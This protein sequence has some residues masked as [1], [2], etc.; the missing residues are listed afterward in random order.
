MNG[1]RRSPPPSKHQTALFPAR[2]ALHLGLALLLV[3]GLAH[4]T[5]LPVPRTGTP[6]ERGVGPA[7]PEDEPFAVE[8]G[9]EGSEGDLIGP[10]AMAP[11]AVLAKTSPA[12]VTVMSVLPEEGSV[13]GAG[14]F[15][16]ASGVVVTSHHLIDGARDIRIKTRGGHVH[17]R[18]RILAEQPTADLALL[19]VSDLQAGQPYLSLGDSA[20]VRVG[21]SVIAIGHPLGLEYTLSIGMVSALRTSKVRSLDL[22]QFSAP[23]S[24]GCSGGPLLNSVGQVIGVMSLSH[25]DGQNLNFAI[26]VNY[27]R[28]LLARHD[29][30]APLGR[31]LR[32]LDPATQ[33]RAVFAA[34]A[35]SPH[36]VP[37]GVELVPTSP[38]ATLEGPVSRRAFR[39]KGRGFDV[40][41]PTSWTSRSR[42]ILD[43]V[44][45]RMES[46][47]GLVRVD[48]ATM[49]V[50]SNA[51]ADVWAQESM[52]RV[53]SRVMSS[54]RA[55][56]GPRREPVL[57]R[58]S[59]QTVGDVTW[60]MYVHRFTDDDGNDD[61]AVTM[62][63]L[64]DG[65]GY[66]VRYVAP[67]SLW[68]RVRPTIER[69]VSSAR[70]F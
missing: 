35:L 48:L 8:A 43:S 10:A 15:T 55:V 67:V 1:P 22:I 3:S 66:L 18:V 38:A 20:Q 57:L 47:D 61:Y 31:V 27:V 59:K 53:N 58:Q 40:Q 63:S 52:R 9:L 65:R 62:L 4:P 51:A 12:I 32:G 54:L 13:R 28:Q 45:V 14:F 33:L 19:E 2:L 36:R 17:K 16:S 30:G 11:A 50:A 56:G 70:I 69:V 5:P 25:P 24:A 39:S 42:C 41:C 26:P 37:A 46:A 44:N 6:L 29:K 68:N 34:P 21:E 7:A 23:V 64:S 60:T 49:A